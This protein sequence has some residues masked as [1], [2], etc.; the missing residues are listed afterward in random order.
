MSTP[1]TFSHIP[2]LPLSSALHSSTKP[3]F[4]ASLRDALLNVGFLYLSDL[5]LPEDLLR[6]VVRE[7][8]GF[9]QELPEVEKERIEMKN[10]KSFLG[11]S[12]VSSE[13]VLFCRNVIA[14]EKRSFHPSG[15]CLDMIDVLAV[16]FDRYMHGNGNSPHGNAKGKV[17]RMERRKEDGT[18]RI[19]TKIESKACN[20]KRPNITTGG[21]IFANMANNNRHVARPRLPKPHADKIAARQR[22]N[23]AEPRSSRT[24]RPVD[25]TRGPRPR[26]A[27]IPQPP[28]A[29]SMAVAG[30]PLQVPASVRGVH[31]AHVAH[32]DAL[33]VSDRRGDWAAVEC[34]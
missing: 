4:L 13:F 34:I 11:W 14:R 31:A 15:E 32:L 3:Q 16:Y 22:N 2:V 17:C 27:A 7:C 33:Y 18:R 19:Y 25:A 21:I 26:R 9:F 1:S 28:C 5:G 30:I 23:S 12:R 10:E 29:E 6:D 24:T 20:H 8:V